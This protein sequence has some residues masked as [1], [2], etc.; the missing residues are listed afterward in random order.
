M[1]T[2]TERIRKVLAVAESSNQNEAMTALLKARELMARHKLTESD[3][4]QSGDPQ[5]GLSVYKKD[6]FTE[7]T[8]RWFV[9]LGKVIAENYCCAEVIRSVSKGKVMYVSFAGLDEDPAI[10]CEVFSYAVQHIKRESKQFKKAIGSVIL[11]DTFGNR[12]HLDSKVIIKRTRNWESSYVTGFIKGLVHRYETQFA[13][14]EDEILALA[15]VPDPQVSGLREHL[16]KNADRKIR[17][18]TTDKGAL[19]KGY[20]DGCR[21]DLTRKA[22]AGNLEAPANT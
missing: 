9:R 7:N 18:E 16:E 2:V 8:N 3:C 4:T 22:A 17:E 14:G 11:E 21:F 13:S 1:S 10:A 6:H 5:M 19:L 15:L 20:H 12:S